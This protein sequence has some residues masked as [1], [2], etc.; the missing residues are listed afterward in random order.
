MGSVSR[1]AF[2]ILF[3]NVC[4]LS[5]KWVWSK[6]DEFDRLDLRKIRQTKWARPKI[7]ELDN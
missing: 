7:N 5:G 3:L 1:V 2:E 6:V 4:A